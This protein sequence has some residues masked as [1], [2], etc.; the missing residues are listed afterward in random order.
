MVRNGVQ[1]WPVM[2]SFPSTPKNACLCLHTGIDY[3]AKVKGLKWPDDSDAGLKDTLLAMQVSVQVDGHMDKVSRLIT[4]ILRDLCRNK[5]MIFMLVN[6]L[7]VCNINYYIG[8]SYS[9]HDIQ[10]G[11][12]S[13]NT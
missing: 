7:G 1:D 8:F 4:R 13:E 3:Y 5:N 9:N 12:E 10:Q 11:E 2:L 6:P